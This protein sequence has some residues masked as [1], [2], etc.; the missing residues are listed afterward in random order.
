MRPLYLLRTVLLCRI[1]SQPLLHS[2][3]NDS[4]SNWLDGRPVLK[5]ELAGWSPRSLLSVLYR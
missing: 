3:C 1:C 2:E 5:F 4:N